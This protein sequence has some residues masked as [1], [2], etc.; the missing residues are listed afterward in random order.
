MPNLK[1]TLEYDGTDFHGFQRQPRLRTVQGTIESCFSR[2]LGENVKLIG[3]GRTDAG[4]HALGQ[5][6]NFHTTRPI[7]PERIPAVLNS[8]LPPDV[9]VQHSQE[10]PDTFHAR[11]CAQSRTYRYTII[12]RPSPSPLL[13][14]HAFVLPHH[15][16]LAAM[17]A[18]CKP[19]PGRRDFRALQASGAETKTT[20]RTLIRLDCRRRNDTIQIVAQADSFLY[21]MVRITVAALLRVGLGALQPDALAKAVTSRRRLPKLGPAPPCGLCLLQVSYGRASAPRACPPHHRDAC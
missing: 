10:V 2:L 13:G 11:R 8:A 4:V 1:L 17:S 9:K 3:A 6:A 14:R 12:E 20:E 16:D 5:V 7:P 18:A 21:R 15:L 19:L